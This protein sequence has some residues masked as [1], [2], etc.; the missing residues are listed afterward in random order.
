MRPSVANSNLRFR[1]FTQKRY[2]DGN[3]IA[4]LTGHALCDL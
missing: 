3:T 1:P 4:F 2:N